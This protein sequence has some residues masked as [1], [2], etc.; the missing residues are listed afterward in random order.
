MNYV[1]KEDPKYPV[2]QQIQMRNSEERVT[3]RFDTPADGKLMIGAGIFSYVA[4][5]DASGYFD[6]FYTQC[7]AE[8][9]PELKVEYAPN[10]TDSWSELD[11]KM[12]PEKF[13]SLGMGQYYECPL[14]EV[15]YSSSN[16]WYDLRVTLSGADES[17]I[18]TISPA[19]RIESV[20]SD[21]ISLIESEQEFE[22]WTIDGV[23]VSRD[24]I[25][26]DLSALAPGL[27]IL[28]AKDSVRKYL[29]R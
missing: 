16:K 1:T 9:V 19:F 17:Q 24:A 7:L 29:A 20:P 21:G 6:Y 8:D 12:D 3:D 18:Q 2:L 10:G 15:K 14:S 22:I 23:L 13:Y 25:D 4:E 27:Y 5:P 11:M 28:R 26:E